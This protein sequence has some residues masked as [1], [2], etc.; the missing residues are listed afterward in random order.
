MWSGLAGD[1]NKFLNVKKKN[2]FLKTIETSAREIQP[3]SA[4]FDIN[5]NLLTTGNKKK[6]RD[7]RVVASLN[8]SGIATVQEDIV[9]SSCVRSKK[10]EALQQSFL[11]LERYG[12]Q[13]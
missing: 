11:Q 3:V 13:I 1:S 6:S 9:L 5:E 7:Y 12:G 10:G 2:D 8:K 4:L